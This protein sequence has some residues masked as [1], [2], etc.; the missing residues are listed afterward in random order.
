MKKTIVLTFVIIILHS[1]CLTAGRRRLPTSVQSIQDSIVLELGFLEGNYVYI[2]IRNDKENNNLLIDTLSLEYNVI[3][4]N[5]A[6]YILIISNEQRKNDTI[7]LVVV[8]PNDY[9]YFRLRVDYTHTNQIGARL[10]IGE[11]NGKAVYTYDSIANDTIL[12]L[13]SLKHYELSLLENN[14]DIR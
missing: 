14:K 10:L 7:P 13:A 1:S 5:G 6:N 2:G 12:N 8:K 4:R 9:L 3:E 11:T